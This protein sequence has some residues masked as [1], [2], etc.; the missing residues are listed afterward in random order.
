MKTTITTLFTLTLLFISFRSLTNAGGP[1]DSMS[2]APGDGTCLNCHGTSAVTSG[3]KWNGMTLVPVGATLATLQQ[4]TTYTFNLTFADAASVKYGFQLCV[5][6][7]GA[8]ASTASLGTIIA[9]SSETQIVSGPSRDYLEHTSS[10]TSAATHTKTWSFQWQTPVSYV[11]GATFYVVVNSTNNNSSND[12]GDVIYVKT[13]A[14]TISLPVSWMYTSAQTVK[15]GVDIQ[16]ATASEVNNWKFEVERSVDQKEWKTIGEVK[17]MGNSSLVNKY[18]YKDADITEGTVYYRVKQIDF[19]GEYSYS[20]M[21]SV[22]GKTEVNKPVVSY[23]PN[24][25]GYVVRGAALKN[26]RVTNMNGE[27]KYSAQVNQTEQVLPTFAPGVY[28]V[29]IQTISG[30]YYEKL[31]MH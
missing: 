13:F 25:S 21:A 24:E 1:P 18:A 9:P 26:I 20:D 23:N 2:G 3:T 8:N 15:E 29:Q 17:G 6:Q 30:T 28:V 12:P 10:G 22:E 7:A 27:T 4:N 11:G 31:L 19:N 16:W 14:A 5:L